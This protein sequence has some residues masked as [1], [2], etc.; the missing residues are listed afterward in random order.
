MITRKRER[1]RGRGRG[2]RVGGGG[3]LTYK[4]LRFPLPQP[5]GILILASTPLPNRHARAASLS[6][7]LRFYPLF[8]IV[9]SLSSLAVNKDEK[10][11]KRAHSG[12]GGEGGNEKSFH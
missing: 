9:V 12:G 10:S 2:V 4:R 3:K 7:S 11:T 1:G 8:S 5:P 6:D